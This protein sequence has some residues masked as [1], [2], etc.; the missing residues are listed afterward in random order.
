MDDKGRTQKSSALISSTIYSFFVKFPPKEETI[1]SI[2]SAGLMSYGGLIG[3][4]C[5][6]DT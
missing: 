6:T 2:A 1:R 3:S 4:Y 5:S